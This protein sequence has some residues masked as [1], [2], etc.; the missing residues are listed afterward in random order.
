MKGAVIIISITHS[1]VHHI[2]ET[3]LGDFRFHPPIHHQ[4]LLTSQ[5]TQSINLHSIHAQIPNPSTLPNSLSQPSTCAHSSRFDIPRLPAESRS[6]LSAPEPLPSHH[7]FNLPSPHFQDKKNCIM[8][9]VEKTILKRH[10]RSEESF[11]CCGKPEDL[12][13]E[14]HTAYLASQELESLSQ[15]DGDRAGTQVWSNPSWRLCSGFGIQ[16]PWSLDILT[17]I[18]LN[19]TLM[20]T[21][22]LPSDNSAWQD[23][24]K[25]SS[26]PQR[27]VKTIPLPDFYQVPPRSVGP[28]TRPTDPPSITPDATFTSH[29]RTGSSSDPSN[30]YSTSFQSFH[31]TALVR[32]QRGV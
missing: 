15:E 3:C 23:P 22:F 7:A 19:R 20:R 13:K 2:M 10:S 18:T 1:H 14:A 28:S 30:N 9:A 21:I 27:K 24:K 12:Q 11:H 32:S 31:E 8:G 25:E 17:L 26:N 29:L 16:S 5:Q 6:R 4:R